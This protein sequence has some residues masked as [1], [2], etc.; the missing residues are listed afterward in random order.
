MIELLTWGVVG[1]CLYVLQDGLRSLFCA[2]GY[3][4]PECCPIC[5]AR[6]KKLR[7]G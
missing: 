2:L 7:E 4:S 6:R 5:R 1:G 3:L